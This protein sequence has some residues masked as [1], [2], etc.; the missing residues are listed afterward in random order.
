MTYLGFHLVFLL[1]PLLLLAPAVPRAVSRFGRRA[2]WTLPAISLIAL[3]YTTPWDNYLVYSGVWWYG[4]DRVLGT[5]GYVPVEEYMFFV[6]QPLLAGAWTYWLLL[7]RDRRGQRRAVSGQ[8]LHAG[9]PAGAAGTLGGARTSPAALPLAS[10]DGLG[11]AR[12][13]GT[14][15]YLLLTAAGALALTYPS[16]RYLGL[17]LAWAAPVLAGQWFFVASRV[18]RAPGLFAAAVAAPTLYLWI[19]DRIAIGAG[20]WTISPAATTGV[21]L[22]GLP[23]EEAVFF[24][25][26]NLLVVQ[27]VF[28]FLGPAM[29][30]AQADRGAAV[31]VTDASAE[32]G[33]VSGVPGAARAPGGGG[34]STA[35][36]A[37][38]AAGVPAPGRG[39][40]AAAARTVQP[41]R[42]NGA[43]P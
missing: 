39:R 35:P 19:A 27:G 42:S 8:T 5:I 28:L 32:D 43:R 4:S 41:T 21:H 25:V 3:V 11:D 37:S 18:M 38:G 7:G 12:N 34:I 9:G 16:G 36:G 13:T 33:V 24:L 23:M 6:L 14:G 31:P 17:V 10:L 20:V 15:I 2:A 1:P 22:L 26:T 40:H 30:A 29:D